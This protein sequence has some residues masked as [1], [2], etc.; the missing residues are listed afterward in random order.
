MCWSSTAGKSPNRRE[1]VLHATQGI[2]EPQDSATV[3]LVRRTADETWKVFL[4]RRHQRQ[5]FMAGA[6]VF[7]GGQVDHDDGALSDY[8]R[9]PL[10]FAPQAAFQ[11]KTIDREQAIR[12]YVC[13]FRETFEETGIMLAVTADGRQPENGPIAR[14]REE[15]LKHRSTFNDIVRRENWMLPLDR[16]IPY[17]HWITPETAPRRFST[18]FFLARL[19]DGQC[20]TTDAVEM[21]DSFWMTPREALRQNAAGGIVLLPPTLKTLEE[22]SAYATPDALWQATLKK[23]IYPILPEPAGNL[24]KLPH[25]PE[26]TIAAYKQRTNPGEPSRIFFRDNIWQT[27]FFAG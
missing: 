8:I 17:A 26:Y 15:I 25:D 27:G 1:I 10:D 22:L 4:A 16:L 23:I 24:L 3:I 13:A 14:L 9:V 6:Y 20:A 12:L 18:W 5:S 19:P 11:K 2:A 7:P 21:T